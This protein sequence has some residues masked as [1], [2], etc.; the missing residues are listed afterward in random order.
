MGNPTA[1]SVMEMVIEIMEWTKRK[2]T[3]LSFLY[4]N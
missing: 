3:L 4:Y 1:N 2:L